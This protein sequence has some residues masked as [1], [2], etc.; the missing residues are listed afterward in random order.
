[1]PLNSNQIKA[2]SEQ[3]KP[4]QHQAETDQNTTGIF[5]W[6][7]IWY[8]VCPGQIKSISNDLVF[9]WFGLVL[10]LFSLVWFGLFVLDL[11]Y[12]DFDLV[13]FGLIWFDWYDRA[14]QTRALIMFLFG[15]VWVCFG[16]AWFDWVGLGNQTRSL[17]WFWFW[18]GLVYM[19]WFGSGWCE[20]TKNKK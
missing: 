7:L 16:L 18:F 20:Q 4:D 3:I 8:P 1:M 9:I 10:F 19:V 11:V 5:D 6:P 12:F 14:N 15:L 2:K 17:V 13:C